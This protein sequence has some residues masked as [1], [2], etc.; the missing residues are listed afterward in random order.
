MLVVQLLNSFL[1]SSNVKLLRKLGAPASILQSLEN[2][3]EN[4]IFRHDGRGNLRDVCDGAQARLHNQSG[5]VY[6]RY[7]TH[8]VASHCSAQGHSPTTQQ[9]APTF[10]WTL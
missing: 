6:S 7:T 5:H 4:G 1:S 10:V 2:N 9:V 3:L 8:V